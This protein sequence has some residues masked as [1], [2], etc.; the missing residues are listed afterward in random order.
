MSNDSPVEDVRE[1]EEREV[2]VLL[3]QLLARAVQEQ[4]LARDARHDG[5]VRDLHALQKK[6]KNADLTQCEFYI[7]TQVTAY[8][9]Y[10]TVHAHTTDC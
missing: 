2:H 4:L 8:P 7:V 10:R 9:V 5:A 3:V 1:G 6:Q